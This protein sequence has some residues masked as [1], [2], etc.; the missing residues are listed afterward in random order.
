MSAATRSLMSITRLGCRMAWVRNWHSEVTL[1][2]GDCILAIHSNRI[3]E[4][5]ANKTKICTHLE[6]GGENRRRHNIWGN[7]VWGHNIW[8]HNMEPQHTVWQVIFKQKRLSSLNSE[9]IQTTIVNICYTTVYAS[10]RGF[11]C[12]LQMKHST[13][14]GEATCLRSMQSIRMFRGQMVCSI[15]IYKCIYTSYTDTFLNLLSF[16]NTGRLSIWGDLPLWQ[17][18]LCMNS[19]YCNIHC[20]LPVSQYPLLTPGNALLTVVIYLLERMGFILLGP[21]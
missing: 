6:M 15:Y 1:S 11:T 3:W 21:M 18:P 2:C 14:V 5:K 20:E 4:L 16:L 12:S 17:Y 10:A 8:G 13:S 9:W 7:D 19:W